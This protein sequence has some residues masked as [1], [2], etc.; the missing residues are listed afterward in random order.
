MPKGLLLPERRDFARYY[1][2]GHRQKATNAGG[3]KNSPESK[4]GG[5]EEMNEDVGSC[6]EK[7]RYLS[8]GSIPSNEQRGKAGEKEEG[9]FSSGPTII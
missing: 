8:S 5:K 1:G 3:G 6:Q 9:F 4:V 2:T 7:R